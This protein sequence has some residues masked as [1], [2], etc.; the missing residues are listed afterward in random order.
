[1]TGPTTRF[2]STLAT[3]P[4][5]GRTVQSRA[6]TTGRANHLPSAKPWIAPVTWNPGNACATTRLVPVSS[7]P[8]A[9]NW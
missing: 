6:E 9:T 7:W 4:R 8:T 1:M 2:G 3:M 5:L